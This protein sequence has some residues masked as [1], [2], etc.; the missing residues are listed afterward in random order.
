MSSLHINEAP[1]NSANICLDARGM[2]EE[3][4]TWFC[5]V[6][7]EDETVAAYQRWLNDKGEFALL[8]R[9][10]GR[11]FLVEMRGGLSCFKHKRYSLKLL[12][13]GSRNEVSDIGG[14]VFIRSGVFALAIMALGLEKALSKI[15]D[16]VEGQEEINHLGPK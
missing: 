13:H 1:S 4:F 15:T 8:S 16:A 2:H 6:Y 9:L 10:T 12:Y 14:R 7:G 5:I 11:D 3:G